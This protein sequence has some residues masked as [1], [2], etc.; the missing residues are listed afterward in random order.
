MYRQRNRELRFD[1]YLHLFD[2]NIV[3]SSWVIKTQERLGCTAMVVYTYETFVS[4]LKSTT[5]ELRE[6]NLFS[7]FLHQ[8]PTLA[9][10]VFK[11]NVP[12]LNQFQQKKHQSTFLAKVSTLSHDGCYFCCLGN[13]YR[14]ITI[15]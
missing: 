8:E 11:K 14:K 6:I 4:R 2:G 5:V 1:K 12:P 9:Q 3:I 15:A 13:V 7:L 10:P